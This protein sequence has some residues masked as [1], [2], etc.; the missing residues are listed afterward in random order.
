MFPPALFTV[1]VPLDTIHFARDLSLD[2]TH[3]SRFFPSNRTIA[4]E[5][6]A[7][8]STPEVT[9]SG[10]GCQ[11]SVSSGFGFPAVCAPLDGGVPDCCPYNIADM[12]TT[13]ATNIEISVRIVLKRI[14]Q[15]AVLWARSENISVNL[16]LQKKTNLIAFNPKS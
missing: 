2:E 4:S 1:S 10:T 3:S 15:D 9:T 5:G 7:L 8:Q 14:N 13:M 11:S 6:G 12:K 16:A